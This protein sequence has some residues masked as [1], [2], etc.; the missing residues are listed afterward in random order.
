M[1]SGLSN[2]ILSVVASTRSVSVDYSSNSTRV[3]MEETQ[4]STSR[5][6]VI[7]TKH[8]HDPKLLLT[9]WIP[10]LL[11]LLGVV[12]Y[13]V[14]LLYYPTLVLTSDPKYVPA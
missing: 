6:A 1:S 3:T 2:K 9:T 7:S 12:S 10:G 13:V 11:H 4:H 14:H 5:R 8:S